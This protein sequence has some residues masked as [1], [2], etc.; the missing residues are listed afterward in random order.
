MHTLAVA[1]VSPSINRDEGYAMVS[2]QTLASPW[3]LKRNHAD[4]TIRDMKTHLLREP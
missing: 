3:K 2:Y 1:F 4:E